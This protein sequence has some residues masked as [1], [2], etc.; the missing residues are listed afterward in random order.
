M[1]SPIGLFVVG[2]R[3]EIQK[4]KRSNQNTGGKSNLNKNIGQLWIKIEK[5]DLIILMLKT[6]NNKAK[7]SWQKIFSSY[8]SQNKGKVVDH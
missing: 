2:K 8:G 1:N 7:N 3:L 6:S 4:Q 5:T